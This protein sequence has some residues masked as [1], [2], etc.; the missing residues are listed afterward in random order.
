MEI[1]FLD[2]DV[3]I[4]KIKKPLINL[5][6]GFSTCLTFLL[7][8]F[9]I[10]LLNIL[11][12]IHW[13][14]WYFRNSS[15]FCYRFFMIRATFCLKNFL[16]GF[17]SSILFGSPL[18]VLSRRSLIGITMITLCIILIINILYNSRHG[19]HCPKMNKNLKNHES[20]SFNNWLNDVGFITCL[21]RSLYLSNYTNQRMNRTILIYINIQY[22]KR[23][24]KMNK[25]DIIWNYNECHLFVFFWNMIFTILKANEKYTLR[26]WYIVVCDGYQS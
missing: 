11:N 2:I 12:A 9:Q 16:S 18:N 21:R 3:V 1:V 6:S 19:N 4:V 26:S 7:F 5:Q 23:S 22:F 15:L 13:H 14:N 20:L 24:S 8:I 17:N 25:I 10:L